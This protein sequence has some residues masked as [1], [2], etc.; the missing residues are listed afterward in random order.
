[1]T[2]PVSETY[3]PVHQGEGPHAGQVTYFL[4]LGLCNLHC[5]WC[6]TPYTWDTTR[7]DIA[8]ECPPRPVAAILATL[9]T[10]GT[11]TLTGGE[12]LLHQGNPALRD[13]LD[14]RPGLAVDVETNGTISPADWLVERVRLFVVSPKLH[15]QGDPEKRRIKPRALARFAALAHDGQAVAKVVCRSE[16]DVD[17]AVASLTGH[18]FPRDRIWIMPEGVTPE[19][20]TDTARRIESATLRHGVHLSL[21]H[22]VLIHGDRRG[23]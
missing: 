5:S 10:H 17:E 15:D 21:R 7:F 2:L 9:P 11:L 18:G 13:L 6:D 19:T 20:V 23:V 4:R 12:P 22:H 1:M 16:A 3:G 8:D 14:S